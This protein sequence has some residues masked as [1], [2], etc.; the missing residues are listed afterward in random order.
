MKAEMDGGFRHL[1][2]CERR[3]R[4][5]A[6]KSSRL[7]WEP[8]R[9]QDVRLERSVRLLLGRPLPLLPQQL[10]HMGARCPQAL[11]SRL[12]VGHVVNRRRLGL[13]R[14]LAKRPGRFDSALRSVSASALTCFFSSFSNCFPTWPS[15]RSTSFSRPCASSRASMASRRSLSCAAYC[16]ASR[17]ARSMSSS[18]MRP[19]SSMVMDCACPC[20]DPS[21]TR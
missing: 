5:G 8:I 1:G 15:A 7:S 12:D 3:K 20:P 10:A 18:D 19:E 13:A 11:G 17:M 9:V 14:L 16:S 4:N 6:R 21:P 2:F